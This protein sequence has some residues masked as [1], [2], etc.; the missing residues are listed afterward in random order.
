MK[1]RVILQTLGIVLAVAAGL[2]TLTG[3]NAWSGLILATLLAYVIAPLVKLAEHPIRVAGRAR[4][5]SRGPA[6]A[7]VYLIIAGVGYAAVAVLLP[8]ASTQVSEIVASAP[9]YTKSFLAWQHG[10]SRYYERLRMPIELR[11][12]VD[13]P[14]LRSPRP[15]SDTR[16]PRCWR[17]SAASPM[18]RGSC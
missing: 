8:R 12:S 13:R 9:V 18:Y 16:A 3:L 10:W 7:L 14:C 17:W 5:L 4:R 11:Q 15:P 6:I 2:W 1:T